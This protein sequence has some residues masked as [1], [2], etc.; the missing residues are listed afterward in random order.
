MHVSCA[1]LDHRYGPQM[2]QA[3]ILGKNPLQYVASYIISVP[4]MFLCIWIQVTMF[5]F[6]G[7]EVIFVTS[8]GSWCEKTESS[9]SAND[10]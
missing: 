5:V 1:S 10:E 3:H 8:G 7:T 9:S 2:L 6:D 4:L